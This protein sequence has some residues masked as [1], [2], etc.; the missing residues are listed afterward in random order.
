VI[1]WFA[2]VGSVL[3]ANLLVLYVGIIP[4]GFG[5]MA[6]AGVAVVG[7]SFWLRDHLQAQGGLRAVIA[8]ILVGGAISAL[9]SPGLALASAT[10]F[11]VSE[12]LDT[13]VYSWLRRR[14]WGLAVVAS[15]AVGIVADS[16]VFLLLAFGSLMYLPGQ[17]WG[18]AWWTLGFL[19]WRA[20]TVLAGAR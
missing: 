17:V 4:V 19:A 2:F 7:L 9:F 15:N 14:S 12:S 8:A 6:P 5:M 13:L 18:K 11:L 1:L 16:L 3:A 20:R 10:A